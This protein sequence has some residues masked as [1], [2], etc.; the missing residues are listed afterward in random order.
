MAQCYICGKAKSTGNNVSH[1]N[2]RTKKWIHPN[3]QRVRAATPGGSRRTRVC[4]RRLR[5]GRVKKAAG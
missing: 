3:L 1:A 4:T 5:R 2:N